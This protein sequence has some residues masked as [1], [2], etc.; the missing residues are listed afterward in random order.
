METL[1]FDAE[2][3]TPAAHRQR[4]VAQVAQW[5]QVI[6]NAGIPVN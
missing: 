5:N 1:V 6:R 2:Q 3:A 4:L